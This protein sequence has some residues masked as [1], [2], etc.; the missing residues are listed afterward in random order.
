MRLR[1][2]FTVLVPAALLAALLTIGAPP[3][4]R[5]QDE[6]TS[7]RHS[8]AD[9]W[10]LFAVGAYGRA[11]ELAAARPDADALALAAQAVAAQAILDGDSDG[12][13]AARVRALA[14]EALRRDP[15]HVEARLQLAVG[16]WLEGRE[17][18]ALQ[19]LWRD[20]PGRGHALLETVLDDT[21]DHA[22][23]HALMGAWHLEVLRRGGDRGARMYGADLQTGVSHFYRALRMDPDN[24][25]IALQC[26]VSFLALDAERYEDHARAVL[27][28]GL[29]ADADDA[30]EAE[31][32]TRS[33]RLW[34]ALDTGERDPLRREVSFW[35]EG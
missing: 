27:A 14:Q 23:A 32:I 25:A 8:S 35:T 15:D 1:S 2:A 10:D 33:R 6:A 4:A 22:W 21:P 7:V 11:A 16:L 20:L 26:A 29:K 13:Q 18:S 19:S 24:A 17:A 9:P 34:Q 30:F 12:D 31:I 3:M 5:A 28:V